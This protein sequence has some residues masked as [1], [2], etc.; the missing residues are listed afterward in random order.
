[1][2]ARDMSTPESAA[3][4]RE[5]GYPWFYSGANAPAVYAVTPGDRTD[6]DQKL[7]EQM[8]RNPA[9]ELIYAAGA[10]RLYHVR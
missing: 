4:M 9:L 6:R 7:L 10:A 5:Q 8:S 3:W 2:Y 1:M